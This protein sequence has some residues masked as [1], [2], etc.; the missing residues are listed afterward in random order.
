MLKCQNLSKTFSETKVL[1]DLSFHIPQGAIFGLLGPNG[2]GK[3]TSIR[4]LNGLLKADSGLATIKG[5][6][7]SQEDPHLR[8]ICGV[9]TEG[10]NLYDQLTGRQNL[11]FFAEIYS[12]ANATKRI[13]N[14]LQQFNLTEA[15]DRKVRTYSTGMRKRL[16]LA[17]TLLHKPQMLFLDEPTSGLDPEAALKV[18]QEIKRLASDE[19]VTILLC[20]HQLKYAEGLCTAYGF[21]DHGKMIA[22]GSWD[23]LLS[24]AGRPRFL[25]IRGSL[26][27]HPTV[28]YDTDGL[29][30]IHINDD[31][32]AARIIHQLI[33][34]GAIIYE[35]TQT[36]L[37]LEDLYFQLLQNARQSA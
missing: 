16:M 9:M 33:N 8:H 2:S 12:L 36:G 26:P 21:L 34:Q 3:T 32:E 13:N 11:S 19:G 14:L 24:M 7:V 4:L 17:R 37:S 29:A 25:K 15:A 5:H 18:N 31:Q 22:N 35:A 28:Q 30:T 1:D 23:E 20:T 6:P 10:A 27:N